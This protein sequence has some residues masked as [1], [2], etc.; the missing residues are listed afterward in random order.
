KTLPLVLLLVS[1]LAGKTFAADPAIDPRSEYA[2]AVRNYVDA[3]EQEIR[4]IRESVDTIVKA[5]ATDEEKKRYDAVYQRL[6]R[7]D[8]FVAMLK[9]AH[10][11]N[12]DKVKAEFERA[13]GEATKALAEANQG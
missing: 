13:R 4:A 11:S 9:T 7:C 6:D 3:A 2:K 8:K 1:L 5:A 10:Q 12:F